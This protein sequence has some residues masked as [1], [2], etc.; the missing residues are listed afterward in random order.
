MNAKPDPPSLRILVV[1]M[2]P[3]AAAPERGI[4][5]QRQVEALRRLGHEVHVAP[6]DDVRTG[7]LRTPWKYLRLAVHAWRLAHATRPQLVHGLYLLPTGVVA[8]WVARRHGIP[9]VV[10]AHG[11]DV[12]N[13]EEVASI[14]KRTEPVV[15][16][17][18][19]V[20]AVSSQLAARLRVVYEGPLVHVSD[21]GV[22][23][24]LFVPRKPPAQ[25]AGATAR[26]ATR[27]ARYVSVGS[28]LPNKNHER[29]LRAAATLDEARLVCIGEG[30]ER[31]RLEQ[32]AG[33]LSMQQRVAFPGRMPPADLAEYYRNVDAA[34]LV[35][36]DEGFGLAALEA[37]ACGA[38]VVV[39]RT[40][41]VAE[42]VADGVNGAVVD[43][44]DIEDITRGLR[45]AGALPH[46]SAEQVR[47]T[48]AGRS[49]DDRA[50]ELA[51]LLAG[52]LK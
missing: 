5:V 42:L 39:S 21:M 36:I 38:P 29:L 24:T 43:P 33:E 40:A 20:I 28:L 27:R 23:T 49:T 34:C 41:P 48:T 17:A 19:A 13:T 2:W 12:R 45:I 9:Y 30:P 1:S 52:V 25:G 26:G 22:D 6:L 16:D 4:F 46:A 37:L 51:T 47:A 18:A 31:D 11:T 44:T 8:R 50:R 3:S 14:R 32:L 7:R 35:S 15:R 10:T